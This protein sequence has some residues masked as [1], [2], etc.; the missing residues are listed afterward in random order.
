MAWRS[1]KDP[2][3]SSQLYRR[4]RAW[5]RRQK[6]P[7]AVCG[8]SIDYTQPDAFVAGHSVA[9]HKAKLL[10]WTEEQI[11]ALSNL[12][13]ECRQCSHRTGAREGNQA[14]RAKR[15]RAKQTGIVIGDDSHSW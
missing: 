11:N 15:H 4:N 3:L 14:K 9:R 13:P 8:R 10:G 6:L 2:L 5:L 7:C 1:S 12:R